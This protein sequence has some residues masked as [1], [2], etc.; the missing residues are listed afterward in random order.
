MTTDKHHTYIS[1]FQG[2]DVLCHFTGRRPMLAYYALSGLSQL[3][4]E[5]A[6]YTSDAATPIAKKKTITSPERA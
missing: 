1:P 2:F 6:K 5:G 3:S 4:P